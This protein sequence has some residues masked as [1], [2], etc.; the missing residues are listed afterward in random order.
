M[1]VT[2]VLFDDLTVQVD[3][4]T[5]LVGGS[6]EG[7]TAYAPDP[8]RWAYNYLQ[9]FDSPVLIDVG[10]CTGSYSLLAAHIPNMKV[11]AFEPV[12]L[13]YDILR[14]NVKLNDLE[15][16]VDCYP[17]AVG[18]ARRN[19]QLKVVEPMSQVALSYVDGKPNHVKNYTEYEIKMVTLDAILVDSHLIK[20]DTEGSELHVLQGATQLI[21]R[22]H[23]ALLIEASPQNS[24]VY[25]YNPDSIE[26]LLKSWEYTWEYIN[27][28]D[29]AA[30][31]QKDTKRK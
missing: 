6:F 11:F 28:I 24:N 10:A 25:G 29:I 4:R 18:E 9:Q 26:A 8:L 21:E 14:T 23:P 19:A 31:W 15:E 13:L 2:A 7:L 20:I 12:P 30:L 3:E 16:Q 1:S 17:Y 27:G 5:A 22:T